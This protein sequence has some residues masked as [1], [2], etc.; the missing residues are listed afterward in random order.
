MRTIDI[1]AKANPELSLEELKLIADSIRSK[2][3]QTHEFRRGEDVLT[4]GTI[5]TDIWIVVS[6]SFSVIKDD[7]YL[8]VIGPGDVIGEVVLLAASYSSN[9]QIIADRPSTAVKLSRA[10]MANILEEPMNAA[11][12]N[13]YLAISVTHK[14]G[15]I[16][17]SYMNF[18]SKLL[19][20]ERLLNNFVSEF[21]LSHVRSHLRGDATNF[22]K[23]NSLVWFSDLVGF[24]TQIMDLDIETAGEA[25]R[26]LMQIQ[27]EKL[28]N[29]GAYLDKFM[30]D[31]VMAYWIDES[32]EIGS[33]TAKSAIRVAFEISALIPQVAKK[34]DLDLDIRIGMHS[35]MAI[36]GDFGCATRIAHTLIGSDV[37]LAARYEQVRSK[38]ENNPLGPVRISPDVFDLLPADYQ[39]QFAAKSVHEVKH[40]VEIPLHDGPTSDTSNF[41]SQ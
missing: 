11:A 29:A 19:E 9:L 22:E 21:S 27:A 40:R 35:G 37:N 5:S 6:G 32:S 2:C 15:S 18:A 39:Q 1:V 17:D 28:V 36:A 16:N 13:H 30:G 31:G 26:E 20:K 24:S 10:K 3:G 41:S 7:F 38:D 8:G 25:T 4:A 33:E 34:Y 14:L 23:V 12:W